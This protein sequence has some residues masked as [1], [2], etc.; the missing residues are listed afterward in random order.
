MFKRKDILFALAVG[1]VAVLYTFFY[2][3]RGLDPFDE[4]LYASEAGRILD[5]AVYGRDFLAPYG[6]G[7]YYLI[8]F[9]F[10]LFGASLKVQ[11]CLFLVLRGV[12]AC[13][14]YFTARRVLPRGWA[15]LIALSL[16]AAHGALHKSFFQVVVL[17]N[18][19]AYFY[20]RAS[21]TP[22]RCLAAGL[23]A[24]AG[25]LFRV[26][27][28]LF[29]A[30]SFAVL[31][32]LE[33]AWDKQEIP[34]FF[35]R[36]GAFA[37]GA[38]LPT[39]PVA[40]AVFVW[41]DLPMVF[42]AEWQRLVNLAGFA[43]TVT[44]PGMFE[45][46]GSLKLAL[47]SIMIYSAPWGLLILG[48]AVVVWRFRKDAGRGRLALLAIAVYG[49][50]VMNQLRITPT[51]NHMLQSAPL[52]L[53]AVTVLL[54]RIGEKREGG[55]GLFGKAA[56]CAALL[57]A[58][59]LVFYNLSCVRPDTVLPGSLRNRWAFTVP[60]SGERAGLYETAQTAD[61]I[62]RVVEEVRRLCPPGGTVFTSPYQ[63]VV[64]FLADR[65]PAAL[66]LEPFYYF[67]NEEMQFK[68]IESIEKTAPSL[69]VLGGGV[70]EVGG[71]SLGRDAPV[72][73]GHILAHYTP[74]A[75]VGSY[76]IWKRI[77]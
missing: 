5:G 37:A 3:D 20:Y 52:A 13:L 69:A 4:G 24:G 33:L 15:L 74:F 23:V 17:A 55:R 29:G 77:R 76:M 22:A 66:F 9:L 41:G 12:V 60:L 42:R 71:L 43:Q 67:G 18:V 53:L 44:V 57:P 26:D 40:A 56:A 59:V 70:R 68:M 61:E 35:R 11:A 64:A 58:L 21:P 73:Y 10:G 7:R 47:L 49:L 62:N 50:P 19:I 28:G 51:F 16:I 30:L 1:V 65:P 25:S 46:S 8:A 32:A 2:F 75:D 54:V 63:P 72:L 45:A 38:L 31:L 34:V 6:P 36:L 14:A 39:L 48:L 27:A